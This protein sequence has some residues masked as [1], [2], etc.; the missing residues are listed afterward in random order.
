MQNPIQRPNAR[1][2]VK[3][4]PLFLRNRQKGLADGK[5]KF[6]LR[7]FAKGD[8]YCRSPEEIQRKNSLFGNVYVF[9]AGKSAEYKQ[10]AENNRCESENNADEHRSRIV[11]VLKFV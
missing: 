8:S 3:S 6:D 7:S 9:V 11:I 2:S 1:I 10:A 4:T 5:E